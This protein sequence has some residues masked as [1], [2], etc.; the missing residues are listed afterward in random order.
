MIDTVFAAETAIHSFMFVGVGVGGG[1][2]ER[3][4]SLVPRRWTV[5]YSNVCK[6]G[7]RSR[8]QESAGARLLTVGQ[9]V[10]ECVGG[11]WI[12]GR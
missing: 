7:S 5:Q 10:W 1:G 3:L 2:E 6:G 4:S 9:C 8:V 12:G 11:V